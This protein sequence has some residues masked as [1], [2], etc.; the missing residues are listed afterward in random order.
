MGRKS[1]FIGGF[2]RGPHGCV[3][4]EGGQEAHAERED[5]TDAAVMTPLG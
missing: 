1:W 5:Q 2:A 3:G 4:G